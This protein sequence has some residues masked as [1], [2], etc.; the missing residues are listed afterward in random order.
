MPIAKL[1]MC[2]TLTFR[3]IRPK[4]TLSVFIQIMVLG[5]LE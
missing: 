4:M 1:L 2:G 5:F 3:K